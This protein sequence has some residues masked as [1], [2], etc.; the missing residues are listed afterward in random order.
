LTNCSIV[1]RRGLTGTLKSK[2][3]NAGQAI[4]RGIKRRRQPRPI[5]TVRRLTFKSKFV[6]SG[7]A[8]SIAYWMYYASLTPTPNP[9]QTGSC[10]SA[11]V[12]REGEEMKVFNLEA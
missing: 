3:E 10:Q 6:G 9:K 1:V 8:V 12:A 2:F 11:R 5:G 7:Q 4:V